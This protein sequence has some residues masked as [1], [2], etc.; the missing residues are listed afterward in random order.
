[1]TM[2]KAVT[3]AK[4]GG[5]EVLSITDAPKPKLLENDV[6]VENKAAG[7]NPVDYK[8]R[9][10]GAGMA[11][12]V[13]ILGWDAAGVVVD[14]GSKV[15][16]L[17]VGD[18]V[19]YAGS[20]VRNGTYAEFTAVDS[21]LVALKPK[22]L[23]WE[24]S[25]TIPLVAQTAYEA[26]FVQMEVKKDKTILIYNGAGGVG[27]MAIQMAKNAGLKVIATAS[28]P[29]TIAWVK[30]LGADVVVNHRSPLKEQFE[31]E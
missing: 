6:L 18:E 24:E 21:R 11:P 9:E 3:L 8:I 16:N 15:T 13:T 30:D 14:I 20:V 4:H 23:T 19:Y 26:L 2:M 28:R 7:T 5:P 31:K 25:A 17:K 22:S 27:S 29:E 12:E 10:H 1:M